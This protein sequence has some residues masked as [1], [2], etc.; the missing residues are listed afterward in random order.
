MGF[1]RDSDIFSRGIPDPALIKGFHF[2]E[3]LPSPPP[4]LPI[5]KGL[6]MAQQGLTAWEAFGLVGNELL[7]LGEVYAESE[8]EA[9]EAA[10][11]R[12]GGLF[13]AYKVI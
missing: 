3:M 2:E 9:L 10:N 11:E 6:L 5:P 4:F 7:A 1:L 8:S 12:G 13:S